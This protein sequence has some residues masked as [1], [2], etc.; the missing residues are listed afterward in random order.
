M[1]SSELGPLAG[2]EQALLD[3]LLAHSFPGVE[4]L[5]LQAKHVEAKSGCECGC[6]SIDLVVTDDNVP[7]STAISPVAEAEVFAS[8]GSGIGGLL[9]FLDGGL[10]SSLEVYS[11]DDPPSAAQPGQRPLVDHHPVGPARTAA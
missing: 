2:D 7:R 3:A 6:G 1:R 9:L 10:L 11:Y 5:R 8:N 4:A